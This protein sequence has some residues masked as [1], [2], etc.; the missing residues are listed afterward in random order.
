MV[1]LLEGDSRIVESKECSIWI[2]PMKKKDLNSKT[3]SRTP[4]SMR[5]KKKR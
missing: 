2:G 4:H 5:R 3:R 1:L